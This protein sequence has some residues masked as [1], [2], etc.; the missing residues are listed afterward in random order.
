MQQCPHEMLKSM[1]LTDL[2]I[3]ALKTLRRL[4]MFWTE[5]EASIGTFEDYP[6]LDLDEVTNGRIP[7]RDLARLAASI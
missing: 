3:E 7:L 6:D 5:V 2:F 4:S 1:V